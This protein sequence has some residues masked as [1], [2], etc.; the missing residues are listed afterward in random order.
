MKK[1][2]L[3]FATRNVNKVRELNA[4]VEGLFN[5]ATLDEVGHQDELAEDY[6][7]LEENARQKAVFIY[8]KYGLNCFSEDTGL[9]ISALGGSP[10]VHTAHYRGTRDNK[11][12]I[13]KVLS[14][15]YGKSDRSARF[16]TV[17]HLIWDGEHYSFEGIVNGWIAEAFSEG[18]EGFGYDPIF[19]PEGFDRTFADLTME[20]KKS[21]SHRAKAVKQLI[22]FLKNRDAI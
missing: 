22:D 16:R 1:N 9:E 8:E 13:Q 11:M 3:V 14:E 21:I 15:M 19:I 7:T 12:N 2:Q 4:Q 10:G 6:E 18:T 17:I 5:I 20:T